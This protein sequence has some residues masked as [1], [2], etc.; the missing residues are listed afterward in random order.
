MTKVYAHPETGYP[1]GYFK[2]P[3]SGLDMT[4]NCSDYSLANPLIDQNQGMDFDD[5][6]Q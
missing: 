4:L 2:T 3:A 6:N 5:V 1:K